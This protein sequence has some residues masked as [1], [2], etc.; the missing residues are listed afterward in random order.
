[1]KPDLEIVPKPILATKP[2]LIDNLKSKEEIVQEP[3]VESQPVVNENA[4]RKFSNAIP[5]AN[6][7][8]TKKQR[9]VTPAAAK[10]IDDEDEPRTS[11][12]IRK[13][14]LGSTKQEAEEN[15]RKVL[16]A[17]ENV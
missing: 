7:S 6:N 5:T 17:I 11:P 12:S 10:A 8:G 2:N 14:S 16:G 13:T 9:I 4:I 3:P 15:D 1:M